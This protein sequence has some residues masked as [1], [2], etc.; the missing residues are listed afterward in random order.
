[1]QKEPVSC[2]GVFPETSAVSQKN[3]VCVPVQLDPITGLV[4]A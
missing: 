1:L 4:M 3:A 2:E